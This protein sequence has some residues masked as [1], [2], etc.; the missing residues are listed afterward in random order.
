VET[1]RLSYLFLAAMLAAVATGAGWIAL[2]G[3]SGA[4]PGGFANLAVT[5]GGAGLHLLSAGMA[6]SAAA[7]GALALVNVGLLLWSR[8]LPRGSSPRVPPLVRV[9]C[10]VFALVLFGV[11]LALILGVP[12]VM[13]WPVDPDTAALFGWIFF[14][15]GFYFAF[16]V[17]RPRW[18]NAR[19]Q[20]WSFVGY[21]AVL[22][23]PLLA[24]LGAVPPEL[25]GNLVVYLVVLLYSAALGLF[26]LLINP[27]T[28]GWGA[29]GYG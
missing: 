3:E 6:A 15:D 9:S 17:A 8:R 22:L 16:A 28:R 7:V 25:R 19:A 23:G 29:A 26:Y 13:P 1:G 12:G 24:H 18:H 20:L 14:G 21:D 2:S 5:L 11:G 4:L 10:S 27:R